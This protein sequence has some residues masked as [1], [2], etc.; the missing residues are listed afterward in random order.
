[1]GQCAS[2]HPSN[3]LPSPA[4]ARCSSARVRAH[5]GVAPHAQLLGEGDRR[6]LEE[7]GSHLRRGE[8]PPLRRVQQVQPRVSHVIAVYG[9][10]PTPPPTADA[11]CHAIARAGAGAQ[12]GRAVAAGAQSR[13]ARPGLAQGA[14][15]T[16]R[17]TPEEEDGVG[18]GEE[19]PSSPRLRPRG[20]CGARAPLA[21]EAARARRFGRGPSGLRLRP[22]P[23]RFLGLRKEGLRVRV[24]AVAAAAAPGAQRARPPLPRRPPFRSGTPLGRASAGVRGRPAP[25]RAPVLGAGAAAAADAAAEEARRE[26]GG[27]GGGGGAGAGASRP[28]RGERRAPPAAARA[29]GPRAGRG[30]HSAVL[31]VHRAH[32]DQKGAQGRPLQA[33]RAR[34]AARRHRPRAMRPRG[35]QLYAHRQRGRPALVLLRAARV[36]ARALLAD[37]LQTHRRPRG[38]RGLQVILAAQE[39]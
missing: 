19:A 2:L 4:R 36:G 3:S 6:L 20:A 29:R 37:R 25:C 7:L 13:R 16:A 12:L 32:V 39:G 35:H 30:D 10:S 34:S 23:V 26:G 17:R 1:M 21:R 5:L 9:T 14:R 27:G 28:G 15:A 22:S 11:P 33:Q 24:A 31:P 8:E 38:A 18:W